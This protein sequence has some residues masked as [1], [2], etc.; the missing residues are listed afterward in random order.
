MTL[1]NIN[2]KKLLIII[3]AA[4]AAIG[5]AVG[6]VFAVL[7]ISRKA[8]SQLSSFSHTD[9][10]PDEVIS[11]EVPSQPADNGIRLNITSSA[12]YTTTESFAVITGT[13]DPEQPL[14]VNGNA[15]ERNSD[16]S[17]ALE[18]QLKVGDNVFT[19]EHKG[20]SKVC[21][22]NYHYTVINAYYPYEKQSYSSGSTFS[23]VASARAGS[24]VA[25]RFNGQTIELSRADDSQEG[26]FVN[27]TGSFTLPS[28][29]PQNLD[30]GGVRFSGRYNGVTEVYTSPRIICLANE[31]IAGARYV[32]RVTAYAAETFDGNTS[33][34]R[35][36]PE[37]SYLPNGTV[38]YCDSGIIYDAGSGNSYYKL[39]CGLRVYVDKKNTPDTGRTVVTTR[40]IEELP[41]HN[42]ISVASFER[43]GK[44]TVLTLNTAWRA[45]FQTRLAPQGYTDAGRQNYTISA[46]TFDYLEIKFFYTTVFSGEINISPDDPVFRAAEV[47]NADGNTLLRL[48]LKKRGAFY[49][50]ESEYNEAGQLCFSFLNPAVTSAAD[51]E[52][53]IDLTGVT[54]LIDAGHGGIDQGAPGLNPS[55]HPESERNLNLAYKIKAELE[56]IGATVK[57]TRSDGGAVF[58]DS[59]CQ[60]IRNLKPDYCV[61]IHHNSAA[62][63]SINGFGAYHF[64]PFSASAATMVYNRT[65]SAG[66]YNSSTFEWHYFYLARMTTC[67]VVLTENGYISGNGDYPGIADENTNSVKAKAIVWGIA[68]YFASIRQ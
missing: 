68:D 51:N 60:I 32:A 18:V 43:N 7:S 64:N 62:R 63:P 15:V 11:S 46:A 49:G 53:G 5:L 21:K 41:D 1:K 55:A 19:F 24:A 39:R 34:D 25:A 2:T 35:S 54:V 26:E 48:H 56:T 23:V 13:S 22:I 38:D 30:L 14:T 42:E 16:G 59:R 40:S 27:Y 31:T 37:R 17:F 29:N 10:L 20:E 9:S 61:S 58:S 67:P 65:V 66:L 28:D 44:H 8:A 50:V 12:D 47:I 52:Y 6:C 3:I 33:D 4:V 36:S 57:M 45:P